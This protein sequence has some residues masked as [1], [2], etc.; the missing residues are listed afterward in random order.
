MGTGGG[1]RDTE[2]SWVKWGH[3]LLHIAD[4]R[5]HLLE[6]LRTPRKMGVGHHDTPPPACNVC[7]Q[8]REQ[9]QG[10]EHSRNMTKKELGGAG[11]M[12][13][14]FRSGNLAS[15]GKSDGVPD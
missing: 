10:H 14:S 11:M 7:E 4:G 3:Q 8:E 5:A 2:D 6:A 1:A 13:V 15:R 12:V 9:R